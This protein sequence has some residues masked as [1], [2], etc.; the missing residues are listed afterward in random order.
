MPDLSG[1]RRWSRELR[2]LAATLAHR[3]QTAPC[4]RGKNDAPICHPHRAEWLRRISQRNGQPARK[5]HLLQL[6]CR[7]EADPIAVGTK[8]R[9]GRIVGAR[10][11][12]WG[13]L[14]E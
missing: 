8:E 6:A 3:K 7:E 4:G 13:Q 5:R 14:V 9:R 11:G 10:N 2:R 1:V 12:G